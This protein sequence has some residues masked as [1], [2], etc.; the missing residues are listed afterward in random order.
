MTDP[1]STHP[2]SSSNNQLS[3]ILGEPLRILLS[4][5][6]TL[7]GQLESIDSSSLLIS[8]TLETR[9]PALTEPEIKYTENKDRYWPRSDSHAALEIK[10]LGIGREIGAVVVSLKD[11]LK[12]EVEEGNWRELQ[13]TANVM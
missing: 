10:G 2:N 13:R 12:V 5:H 3:L 4:D 7:Q 11:V 6:R 8:S 9:A 1:K